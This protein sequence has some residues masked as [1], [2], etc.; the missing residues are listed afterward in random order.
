MKMIK[1]LALSLTSVV[2]TAANAD[3]LPT[4]VTTIQTNKPA[5]LAFD[6]VHKFTGEKLII[7][8]FQPFWGTDA[9]R[10]VDNIEDVFGSSFSA[11]IETVTT[12]I[13]WPNETHQTP[14]DVFAQ[15]SL[16]VAGGFLVWGSTNGALTLLD[17]EANSKQDL[18]NKSGWWYHRAVWRDMNQDGRRDIITARANKPFFGSGK[19]HLVWLEQPSVNPDSSVWTEHEIAAGPD[20]N[21][22]VVDLN[23]N[24]Q[25]EIVATEFFAQKLSLHWQ[26]SSGWQSRV[27]DDTLGSAFDVQ[28]ADLNND[29]DVELLVTNHESD[30]EAAVFAYEV[31]GDIYNDTWVRHTLIDGIPTNKGG[32]GQASPGQAL[33][34]YPNSNDQ[35][36]KPWIH[37]NGDGSMQSHLLVPS[38]LAT[39]DWRYEEHIIM[40]ANNSVIGQTA[41]KDVNGDGWVE[42]FI[43]AY[44]ENA[45][46]VYSFAP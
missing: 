14:D 29:G 39:N 16:L 21:F 4:K 43:P 28:L 2:F 44:D 46:H 5:F 20:V 27:I 40:T 15:D 41:I 31:P 42:L 33:A 9:V 26:T 13:N 25:E 34:F 11:Q 45:I 22:Q 35:Q 6:E 24:G 12:S 19:G 3:V 8:S 38:S 37:V 23:G 18:T 36:G 1:L 17:L 7:N 10:Y 32:Q 30:D